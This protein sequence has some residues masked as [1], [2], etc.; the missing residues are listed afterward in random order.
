MLESSEDDDDEPEI[1]ERFDLCVSFD[2]LETIPLVLDVSDM[3]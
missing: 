3:T 1:V 2:F